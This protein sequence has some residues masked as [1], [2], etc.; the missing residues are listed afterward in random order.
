[1][2]PSSYTC[3]VTTTTLPNKVLPPAIKTASPSPT[4]QKVT[5]VEVPDVDD[6]FPIA[7]LLG[8]PLTSLPKPMYFWEL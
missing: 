6:P 8:L 7:T 2:T 3:D 1:M 5:C 4:Q